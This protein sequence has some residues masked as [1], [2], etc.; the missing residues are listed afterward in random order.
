MIRREVDFSKKMYDF[1]FFLT[2]TC[3]L[4]IFC[5]LFFTF[6]TTPT[7][8]GWIKKIR[9]APGRENMKFFTLHNDGVMIWDIT[10]EGKVRL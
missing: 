6:R 7:N 4:N 10:T 3:V 1:G 2:C 8:R 9:F 5:L